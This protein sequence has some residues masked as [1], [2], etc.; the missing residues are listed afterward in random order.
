M[1]YQP[2]NQCYVLKKW[3]LRYKRFTNVYL[4]KTL[5]KIILYEDK[6]AQCIKMLALGY[7]DGLRGKMGKREISE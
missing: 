2:R 1:Y 5:I 7:W 4:W 6:K 3:G